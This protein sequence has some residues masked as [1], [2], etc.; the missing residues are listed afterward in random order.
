MMGKWDGMHGGQC[1][2]KETAGKVLYA[3]NPWMVLDNERT[4]H[5]LMSTTRMPALS[6]ARLFYD[7]ILAGGTSF[8]ESL[9][10]DKTPETEWLD[11]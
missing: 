1:G 4:V 8:I 9:V 6:S 10:T 11:F 2:R 3:C 7:K 5:L